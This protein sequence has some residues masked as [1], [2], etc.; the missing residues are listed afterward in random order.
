MSNYSRLTFL[1]I[2]IFFSFLMIF[3]SQHNKCFPYINP[4]PIIMINIL[5]FFSNMNFE[6]EVNKKIQIAFR[7][8]SSC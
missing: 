2:S 4:T 8:I 6:F 5:F 7:C 1:T 3:Y